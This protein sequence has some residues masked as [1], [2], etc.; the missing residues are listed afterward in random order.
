MS[1]IFVVAFLVN[2]GHSLLLCEEID[3]RDLAFRDM[4]ECRAQLGGIVADQQRRKGA[5]RVVM[6]KCRYLLVDPPREPVIARGEAPR[7]SRYAAVP[8][9]DAE[10]RA[11]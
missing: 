6:G 4:G 9:D 10:S 11:E 2:C 5:S 3:T 7:F 1:G 8:T